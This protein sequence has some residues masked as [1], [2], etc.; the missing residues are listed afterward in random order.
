MTYDE[1]NGDAVQVALQGLHA[2]FRFSGVTVFDTLDYWV[3]HHPPD[4][5]L[6]TWLSPSGIEEG[7]LTPLGLRTAVDRVA[8][9]LANEWDVP[10]GARAILCYPPGLDFLVAMLAC[11]RARVVAVPVYPPH[12]GALGRDLPKLATVVA[13]SGACVA[14]TTSGYHRARRLAAVV[15]AALGRALFRSGKGGAGGQGKTAVNAGNLDASKGPGGSAA[16]TQDGSAKWPAIPWHSTDDLYG[17]PIKKGGAKADRKGG[18]DGAAGH[19]GQGDDG[20]VKA[21]AALPG[22]P[23][24]CSWQ[25]SPW[26]RGR[27]SWDDPAYLQYSSGSTSDP[28]GVVI[29]HRAAL[30]NEAAASLCMDFLTPPRTV[31]RCIANWMPQYHDFG[32]VIYLAGVVFGFHVVG[33]AP[34]TFL[35]NPSIWLQ[36]ISTHCAFFSA[37]PNFALEYCIRKVPSSVR[38]GLDLS[39]L[40]IVMLGGEPN[41]AATL[42][43][44]C[45]EFAQCGFSH[46]ALYPAY[47]LAENVCMVS[48][49]LITRTPSWR[50]ITVSKRALTEEGRC[51]LLPAH[52]TSDPSQGDGHRRRVDSQTNG[53]AGD[54]ATSA[55]SVGGDPSEADRLTLVAHGSTPPGVGAVLIV[56]PD[57]RRALPEMSLG[58][59]WLQTPWTGDGYFGLEEVSHETFGASPVADGG[60]D[61]MCDGSDGHD[62]AQ[63][64]KRLGG[65]PP[66]KAG[67][68][69]TW[70]R[71]GD[72][73][74]L[75]GGDLFVCGRCKDLIIINGRNL[76]PQDVELSLETTPA[77]RPGC[78]AVF[79]M[80]RGAL[81]A[82]HVAYNRGEPRRGQK[83]GSDGAGDRGGDVC[84][85]QGKQ[86]HDGHPHRKPQLG[87][88]GGSRNGDDP[89]PSLHTDSHGGGAALCSLP[90]L[91][92]QG[93]E[94]AHSGNGV[95]VANDGAGE[96]PLFMN[97]VYAVAGHDERDGETLLAHEGADI[98]RGA[99]CRPSEAQVGEAG[100]VREHGADDGNDDDDADDE[101][102]VAVAEVRETVKLPLS[103]AAR[104]MLDGVAAA[105][106][107]AVQRDHAQLLAGLALIPHHSI[108]KTSSGKV[109]RRRS[110]QL[111]QSGQLPILHLYMFDKAE[112]PPHEQ[113]QAPMEGVA[114][115]TAPARDNAKAATAG[116]R[117]AF[118]PPSPEQLVHIRR[119]APG[120]D[121]QVEAV[122]DVLW[123]HVLAP[124][125][126]PDAAEGK[127][128]K[129][130][131]SSGSGGPPRPP[132]DSSLWA[133]G[134]TS[135]R[136]VESK[137]WA[138]QA[139]G[140]VLPME[141]TLDCGSV[142]DM[143]QLVATTLVGAGGRLAWNSLT[144]F[145]ARDFELLAEGPRLSYR[146]RLR[147]S[148]RSSSLRRASSGQPSTGGDANAGRRKEG[149]CFIWPT[150]FREIWQM[151]GIILITA[152]LFAAAIPAY[153]AGDAVLDRMHLE[154]IVLGSS[155][156]YLWAALVFST[157]GVPIGVLVY[158]ASALLLSVIFKWVLIGRYREG[159][160]PMWS[161]YFLRWWTV[162]RMVA[163]SSLLLENIQDTP[164]AAW[165]LRA[166]GA[167]VGRNVTV[168]S[169]FLSCF[170]LITLGDGA[171]V[172]GMVHPYVLLPGTP[173]SSENQAGIRK[174]TPGRLVLK[175]ITIGRNSSVAGRALCMPGS[176][177]PDGQTVP[178]LKVWRGGAAP[179]G[180][181]RPGPDQVVE[182][183]VDGP[184]LPGAYGSTASA[185][186][187]ITEDDDANV[188][189]E[190]GRGDG[191]ANGAV[192][193]VEEEESGPATVHPPS[194]RSHTH[195]E[196][197]VPSSAHQAA[198]ISNP[199][200]SVHDGDKAGTSNSSN[201]KTKQVAAGAASGCGLPGW[202]DRLEGSLK[203]FL[204]CCL[205]W[206]FAGCLVPVFLIKAAVEYHGT[207]IAGRYTLLA[208]IS[209]GFITGSLL[210]AFAVV[211]AKWLLIG[212]LRPG[213]PYANTCAFR[214]RQWLYRR[215]LVLI[216]KRFLAVISFFSP[217]GPLWMRLMGARVGRDTM[218]AH[219]CMSADY[220][221]QDFRGK[222]SIISNISLT[223]STT[224]A[225]KKTV[226]FHR[227]TV[228]DD[229]WIGIAASLPPG[230]AMESS[231][232]VAPLAQV[233]NKVIKSGTY[234]MGRGAVVRFGNAKHGEDGEKNQLQGEHETRAAVGT[235]VTDGQ[236]ATP[237]GWAINGVGGTPNVDTSSQGVGFQ[238]GA[239]TRWLFMT[240]QA[241]LLAFWCLLLFVQSIPVYEYIRWVV[242]WHMPGPATI[243]CFF[244]CYYVAVATFVV[245][246]YVT[247]VLLQ[248]LHADKFRG[249]LPV[250]Y[251]WPLMR[252]WICSQLASTWQFVGFFN[253]WLFQGSFIFTAFHRLMGMRIGSDV[254]LGT[255][256]IKEDAMITIG[257]G[258]V[259]EEYAY[260]I[261]HI[262]QGAD[263]ALAIDDVVIGEN[264]HVGK[265]AFVVAGVKME[266][267]AWLTPLSMP[268]PG[269]VLPAGTR[270]AGAPARMLRGS[271]A[272][273]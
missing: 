76:F 251:S 187:A 263:K 152:T 70:L 237:S 164:L 239:F 92:F 20:G 170:D 96:K 40:R 102:I 22:G 265:A 80:A 2:D 270:W 234:V 172:K 97:K 256:R 50:T 242:S 63:A 204:L 83:G 268:L 28:K 153:A 196:S 273:V 86:G 248:T 107:E 238:A 139:F 60:D 224:S 181:V 14:L 33:M 17:K 221:M 194:H 136:L 35:S 43:R 95:A 185:L 23:T 266:D 257:D 88:E 216:D 55:A 114:P 126:G 64:R 1:K 119:Q 10:V 162:E 30:L 250:D 147:L 59:I 133:L 191:T 27:P 4:A 29:S 5:R 48:G 200:P 247:G 241:V 93:G 272:A 167:T 54:A 3:A 18:P 16:D 202:L 231:S 193:E 226:T 151:V 206:F 229:C 8:H 158:F 135:L 103:A 267:G 104:A 145:T 230:V 116:A 182:G 89:P 39:S 198:V 49:R 19:K 82:C 45:K 253:L 177:L 53:V 21:G 190:K 163:I 176:F 56:D 146:D 142:G 127:G 223:T 259:I 211:V 90:L 195:G 141:A 258:A 73:G 78:S 71:T 222:R 51:K 111:L 77:L 213:V 81:R 244:P 41:R 197:R 233:T 144:S 7:H 138:E 252:F 255:T 157:V 75:Q 24:S 186:A 34:T 140:V 47:G 61:V 183:S 201:G 154:R 179:A 236:G 120:S 94:E 74:F 207:D 171:S 227:C 212:R 99:I 11:M 269:E 215:L 249:V 6:Y 159:S 130:D 180:G 199:S 129:G 122:A 218:T 235:S 188:G 143:A 260:V 57:T 25:L 246:A 112:Q 148:L 134:M 69:G 232:G 220:D 169:I 225:D 121:A 12:P 98:S 155:R 271:E 79:A 174:R 109:Q 62:G 210:L 65:D 13:S 192:D 184:A 137:S 254:Y 161:T 219:A 15:P 113:L 262:T 168:D 58:E 9:S 228:G 118:V 243:L 189:T 100:V 261:G 37:C 84:G 131:A 209:I 115:S 203:V 125:L 85:S 208:V 42:D 31:G 123:A 240:A 26:P 264:C 132:L 44:F 108:P 175:R 68:T 149:E 36:A 173:A 156:G 117:R 124:I 106:R 128:Y 110:R 150:P 72:L 105:V 52:V 217:L 46:D 214:I 166:M 205:P 101:V 32:L 66:D 160:Y 178:S 165:Y 67:P 91:A 38:Q 245:V 87:E